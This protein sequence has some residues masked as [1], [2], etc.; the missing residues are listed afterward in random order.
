MVGFTRARMGRMDRLGVE[1]GQ[2][3]TTHLYPLFMLFH[4]ISSEPDSP[5]DQL[6]QHLQLLESR[7]QSSQDHS[8]GPTSN[9]FTLMVARRTVGLLTLGAANGAKDSMDLQEWVMFIEAQLKELH[10]ESQYWGDHLHFQS[11]NEGVDGHRSQ[12][13]QGELIPLGCHVH[14]CISALWFQ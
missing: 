9:W 5:G 13:S 14:A 3:V 8:K 2:N 12:P 1:I 7:T 6:E 4:D 11:S 10:F